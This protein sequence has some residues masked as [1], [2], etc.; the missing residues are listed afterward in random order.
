M[1]CVIKLNSKMITEQKALLLLWFSS[2]SKFHFY[3]SSKFR[4]FIYIFSNFLAESVNIMSVYI[5]TNVI[6]RHRKLRLSN[7]SRCF[8]CVHLTSRHARIG[9]KTSLRNIDDQKKTWNTF[10]SI[11]VWSLKREMKVSPLT[12]VQTN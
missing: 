10:R 3:I 9:S 12:L 11:K 2:F 4:S 7:Q 8:S 5:I 1:F 6:I